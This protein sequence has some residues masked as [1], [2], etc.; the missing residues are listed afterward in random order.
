MTEERLPLNEL[1]QKA[2]DVT[3]YVLCPRASCNC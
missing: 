2:S 3:F 1:L